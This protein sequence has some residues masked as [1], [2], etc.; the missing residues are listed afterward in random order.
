[1]TIQL[2]T[3]NAP[4]AV[5]SA[6]GAALTGR[7]FPP[8]P[9]DPR[10]RE[11]VLVVRGW[12]VRLFSDERFGYFVPRGLWHVQLWQPERGISV[13][14]PSRL[15]QQAYE[16]F[17]VADWKRRVMAHRELA[18]LVTRE[19]RTPFLSAAELAWVEE[20]FVSRIVRGCHTPSGKD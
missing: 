2:G 10:E 9:H 17:P 11:L 1:M 15:T 12:Q 13:L 8:A 20:R 14:T 7:P 18:E 4:Q 3:P 6:P 19:H 16:L 5:N